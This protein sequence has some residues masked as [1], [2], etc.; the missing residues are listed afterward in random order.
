MHS[1]KRWGIITLCTLLVLTL[2]AGC[3]GP[4]QKKMKFYNKGKA[5][6][7]KGD[8]VKAGLEF[9]NAIQIDPKFADAYYMGGMVALRQGD[10]R[11]AFGGFSKVVE[12]DPKHIKANIEL[13]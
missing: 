1:C 10:Y 11:R 13:A 6:Y 9:R 4:E 7:E 12:L 8:Y 2:I 5:L 3:G